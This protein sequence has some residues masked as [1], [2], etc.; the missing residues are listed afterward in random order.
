M[1]GSGFAVLSALAF[2]LNN[3]F[4]RRAVIKVDDAA[5]G[6][7][8]T[9]PIGLPFFISIL[10]FTGQID[11]IAGFSWRSYVWFSA[12]GILHYVVGRSLSYKCIQLVGANIAGIL[13]RSNAVVAVVLGISVLG[14]SVTWNLVLGVLFIVFGLTLPGL[15]Q[16]ILRNRKSPFSNLLPRAVLFGLGAGVA[17]GVSPILIKVG[18]SGSGSPVAGAFISFFAATIILSISLLNH[19]RYLALRNMKSK[20][21][22]LFCGAGLLSST[23]NLMRFVAL[24]VAP[25]S[26][27]T[28]LISVSP[29][30]L[31]ILSFMFNR[32]LELFNLSII[33]GILS[34]V[35]GSILIV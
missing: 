6:V 2:A 30:F 25:A 7:L 18:L 8:I 29:V 31:L 19:D 1:Y 28:P 20:T 35:I 23:A 34:V 11:S 27:V 14:E 5:T 33:L 4:T 22:G 17:W 16:E 26:I 32:K 15:N 13:L 10:I 21:I 24:G 12:A 3:V 9:V